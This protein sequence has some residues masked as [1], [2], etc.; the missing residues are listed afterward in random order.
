MAGKQ[1]TTGPVLSLLVFPPRAT[2]F[3][4]LSAPSTC[5]GHD[6]VSVLQTGEGTAE[7]GL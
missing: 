3:H 1:V 4:E 5:K 7:L 6:L 2:S